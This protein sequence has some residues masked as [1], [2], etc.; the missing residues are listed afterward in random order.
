MPSLRTL[1][2]LLG[3]RWLVEGDDSELIG[4]SLDLVAD[5]SVERIRRGLL[6]RFPQGNGRTLPPADALAAAGKDRQVIRGIGETDTEYAARLIPW[7]DDRKTQGGPFALMR[8]LAAYVRGGSSFR[9][10]DQRGNWFS[11]SAAGVETYTLDTGN[12]NWDG[13]ADTPNWARFWVIIYPGTTWAQTHQWGDPGLT[14]GASGLTW[15]STATSGQVKMT[16]QIVRNWKPAGTRCIKIIVAFDTAS[17]DPTAPEPDGTWD[18]PANRLTTA[19][20]W[21]GT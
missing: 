7:L 5:A 20:Y 15:G 21:D 1:R 2:P 13:A 3:P 9:T 10:V 19:A 6:A 17:F 14:W 8:T 12:W 4:Y 16:R 18:D 11:R